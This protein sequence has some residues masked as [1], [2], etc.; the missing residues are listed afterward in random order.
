MAII[1]AHN[2]VSI[3]MKQKEVTKTF[4]MISNIIEKP[5]C[6]RGLCKI[7]FGAVR[8][9]PSQHLTVTEFCFFTAKIRSLY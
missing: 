5:I 2:I 4:M 1:M 7:Y 8:V 9:K 6:L 3:Q